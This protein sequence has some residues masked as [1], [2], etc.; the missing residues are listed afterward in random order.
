MK[1]TTMLF[2]GGCMYLV[3]RISKSWLATN[4]FEFNVQLKLNGQHNWPA[5]SV[6]RR[7]RCPK[8]FIADHPLISYNTISCYPVFYIWWAGCDLPARQSEYWK[9]LAYCHF[10]PGVK[11]MLSEFR[12]FERTLISLC[13]P[14]PYWHS[15]FLPLVNLFCF[16]LFCFILFCFVLFCFF[17]FFH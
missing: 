15:L 14:I 9:H 16:V 8:T 10:P 13:N 12:R 4:N 1:Q 3:I 17:F 6:E 7:G 5:F 2:P 11:G